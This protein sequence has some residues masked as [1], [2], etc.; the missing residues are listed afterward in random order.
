MK[1][2]ESLHDKTNK[3][4]CAASEDSDQPGHPLSLISLCNLRVAKDPNLLQKD[5]KDSDQTGLTG[6]FFGFVMQWLNYGISIKHTLQRH[7]SAWAS[8]LSDQ[9]LHRVLYGYSSYGYSRTQVSATRKVHSKGSDQTGQ[10]P[11]LI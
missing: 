7:S 5:S 3:I 9:N 6:Q 4:T 10:M 8:T 2:H 1:K 11:R